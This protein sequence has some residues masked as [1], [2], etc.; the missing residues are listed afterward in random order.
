MPMHVG[1]VQDIRVLVVDESPGLTQ[2]L[3]LALP[4]SGPVC[5]LGPVQDDG[6]AVVA[7]DL[8]AADLVVVDI[9][10]DDG[11]GLEVLA[12]V[13]DREGAR[14][15]A[16]TQRDGSEVAAEALAAGACGLLPTGRGAAV[17]IDAF[18]RAVAG[19]LVLPA[20]DLPSLVERLRE[21]NPDQPGGALSVLTVRE[22]E[23]LRLLADGIP[24]T[25]IAVSLGISPMTVQ[26]HLKNI[27]AKL[28]VH[29]KVAAVRLAWRHGLGSALRTA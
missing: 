1:T 10:R 27:L 3:L 2:G 9:D 15:L 25:D 21:L 14:V 24:T 18:R 23:I 6:E 7:L 4:R 5:V 17:L 22:R 13:S 12:A 29:S 8:A 16:S 28:G 20:A 19:E 11:R 26:S